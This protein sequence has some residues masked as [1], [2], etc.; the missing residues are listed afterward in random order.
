[1]NIDPILVQPVLP[2][3]ARNAQVVADSG[4][5]AVEFYSA[6]FGPYPYSSLE[7]T[8]M[9]GRTSQG[10]PGLV[11]LSSYAF[12]T[13]EQAEDLSG[14]PLESALAGI[15]LPHETAHQWWGD[16]VGWR[17]YRDQ[18]IVEALANY[19]ALMMLE[20]ERPIDVRAVLERYRDELAEKNKNYEAL[21]DAGPVTLG[22]RLSSSHFP[23]G[24]EAISYGRGTWL[25]HMLR[26]MLLNTEPNRTSQEERAPFDPEEPFVRALRKVRE[27]YAGKSIS[28]RE[29]FAVF[30]ED[31]PKPLWYEG[32]KSLDWFVRSWVEGTALPVFS[33]HNVKYD[34][35]GDRT[36]VV[37]A[38]QQR[39][40]P[41]DYVSAVPVYALTADDKVL[42]GTVLADGPETSFRLTAPTGTRKVVLDPYQTLLTAPK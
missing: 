37:G 10:W 33:L 22:L 41:K 20:K 3:P 40:T 28:T 13:H 16:L 42:I 14:S 35:K 23:N 17:S 30:E 21:R 6:R 8:Q 9:P 24:Y 7:L 29:L 34:K 38:I 5:R 39:E 26:N 4:A 36:Q 18:W 31:L 19:S 32:H 12:L 25:F 27:R 1:M 11:F 2:S 15:A